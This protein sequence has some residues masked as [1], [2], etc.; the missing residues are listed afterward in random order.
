MAVKYSGI[1]H[2]GSINHVTGEGPN[3]NWVLP[4]AG[5][6]GIFPGGDPITIVPVVRLMEGDTLT[7]S[8][9]AGALPTGLA[10]DSSTG[11]ISGNVDNSEA[12]YS[13]TMRADCQGVYADRS[14]SLSV[15]TNNPPTWVTPAG[16]LGTQYES[17]AFTTTLVANGAASYV[18][19]SGTLPSGLN[20]NSNTG[21]ISGTLG[22]VPSTSTSFF[23]IRAK[24]GAQYADRAFN[25]T[26]K[27]NIPPQWIS[28][29]G[30]LGQYLE[31]T[32]V[33]YTFTASNSNL[34][35]TL[36]YS[37]IGN[38]AGLSLDANTGVLSGAL[39]LQS[40][41]FQDYNFTMVASNGLK[42]TPLTPPCKIRVY[43]NV[44]PV[45]NSSGTIATKL[46]GTEV[47][48][49]LSATDAFEAVS[50][51]LANG[52]TLPGDLVIESNGLLHGTLPIIETQTDYTF[53]ANA[54]D[55]SNLTSTRPLKITVL[56]NTKPAWETDSLLPNALEAYSYSTFVSAVDT[57]GVGRQITYT[58]NS[59]TLPFT[60]NANTGLISGL[61]PNVSGD[62]SYTFDIDATD[63]FTTNTRTFSLTINEDVP[64]VWNANGVYTYNV[65][66]KNWF[67]IVFSATDAN[68][69]PVTYY[70]SNGSLP[71]GLNFHNNEIKGQ[72]GQVASDTEYPLTIVASDG[73]NSVPH[74]FSI[75][76]KHNDAPIWN[77]VINGS[78]YEGTVQTYPLD[79]YD[80]NGQLVYFHNYGMPSGVTQSGNT[81]TV[82][83]PTVTQDTNISF[84]IYAADPSVSQSGQPTN[85]TP[86]TFTV[87]T[88]FNT[89]P[90]F[91]DSNVRTYNS[92]FP[93]SGTI[94]A[95]NS[96]NQAMQYTVT[97]GSLP[98]G[99]TLA[100]NGVLLGTTWEQVSNSQVYNFT[101]QADNGI[102]QTSRDY[103]FTILEHHDLTI[104][105]PSGEL[106]SHPTNT[107][108]SIQLTGT[109]PDN[110]PV[111]WSLA[112]GTTLP[113]YI[114]LSSSG[115][116]SGAFAISNATQTFNFEVRY[117]DTI[118]NAYASYSLTE[119]DAGVP[120]W[121]TP[122][123][124]LGS[125]YE[126][127]EVD[128]IA[129]ATDPQNLSL[130]FSLANGSSLPANCVVTSQGHVQGQFP[131]VT[132]NTTYTFDMVVTNQNDLSSTRTFS[133]TNL[134]DPY[135]TWQ[136][137]A[138][139]L[140]NAISGLYN[141]FDI[142]A[143]SLP[144][145][146]LTYELANGTSVPAG[147]GT[148]GN[149]S[150]F[151]VTGTPT[152]TYT[153]ST[154]NFTVSATDFYK[155]TTIYRD[156][157]INVIRNTD[158][159]WITNAGTLGTF[160]EGNTI[161]LSVSAV[162]MEG[163]AL[164]YSLYNSTSV[165]AGASFHPDGTITGTLSSVAQDTISNFTVLVSD[166]IRTS[167]RDFSLTTKFVSPPVWNTSAGSLGS[168]LEQ[169]TFSANVSAT[170]NGHLLQ[171]SLNSGS[172]PDSLSLNSNTGTISGYLDAISGNSNVTS[173]FT[174][175]VTD[176]ITMKTSTRSFSITKIKN[177]P[178][179]WD[180]AEGLIGSG[181]ESHSLSFTLVAHDPNGTDVEFS[182]Q[183]GNLPASIV[184]DTGITG[185]SLPTLSGTYP[186]VANNTDYQITVGAFDGA[187]RVD[188]T[189]T[190]TALFN[191][192]PVWVTNAGSLGNAFQNS[193][194][195]IALSSTDAEGNAITYTIAD[196]SLPSGLT[197]ASNGLI[198]GKLT[199]IGT[200]T[201]SSFTVTAND[202]SKTTDRIFSFLSKSPPPPI[203]VTAS[204]EI[205]NAV[206]TTTV[207]YQLVATSDNPVSYTVN[208]GTFP[209]ELTL[210]S[211][212][213]YI[214][215]KL[216]NVA[217][218]RTSTFII[219][220]SDTVY[221][222]STDRSF[223]IVDLVN[224]APVWVTGN[225]ISGTEGFPINVTLVATDS[226]GTTP[227]YTNIG[228]NFAPSMS[229]DTNTHTIT[230]TYPA[231]A[232]NSASYFLTVG[233]GDGNTVTTRT[234]TVTSVANQPPVWG[235][236]GS[237]GA[238]YDN[239]VVNITLTA[240]DPEA[241]SITYSLNSGTLPTGLSLVGN[242]L[243]GILSNTADT[244]SSFV[245]TANDGVKQTN[246]SFTLTKIPR[247]YW[248]TNAGTLTSGEELSSF[249]YQL[250][251]VD[252]AMS[253]SL[254]YV[255]ESKD[256]NSVNVLSNGL[257]TG[258]YPD[259]IYNS[260]ITV[261]AVDGNGYSSDSKV[262]NVLP[263]IA[264]PANAIS[265][266]LYQSARFNRVD[267]TA[268][269]ALRFLSAYSTDVSHPITTWGSGNAANAVIVTDPSG[270]H[271]DN[272][273][274]LNSQSFRYH[275]TNDN[276]SPP[277][278]T[279]TYTY[280]C[281]YYIPSGQSGN[282]GLAQFLSS[283]YVSNELFI[284]AY[285]GQDGTLTTTYRP[286]KTGGSIITM[287]TASGA[288]SFDTWIHYALVRNGN[289]VSVYLNGNL[290]TTTTLT[291]NFGVSG[292]TD[293]IFNSAISRI[294]VRGMS[295]WSIARY[296]SKFTPSWN[297]YTSPV[298]LSSPAIT[299]YEFSTYSQ[300]IVAYGFGNSTITYNAVGLGANA[301]LEANG[302]LHGTLPDSSVSINASVTASDG[303]G[304]SATSNIAYTISS[305]APIWS[306]ASNVLAGVNSTTV[307]TQFTAT[308]PVGHSLTYS[309]A[310]G[311]VPTGLTF[312]SNG[313]LNGQINVSQSTTYAFT[314]RA[315][316]ASSAKYTD[317]SFTYAITTPD[318]YGSNVVVLMNMDVAT[319]NAITNV[320]Q[321]LALSAAVTQFATSANTG[322]VSTSVTKF[323]TGSVKFDG[324][325]NALFVATPALS[326]FTIECW[327]YFNTITAQAIFSNRTF[328]D[329][330]A[331]RISLQIA[332]NGLLTLTAINSANNP[333]TRTGTTTLTTGT[334]YHIAV[335]KDISSQ[336][337]TLY[338][339]GVSQ[340][341]IA[342][343]IPSFTMSAGNMAI[344]ALYVSG[345]SNNFT[346][347][348]GYIDDFRITTS[349]RYTGAFTPPT[350]PVDTSF[351]A[352][353]FAS[354]TSTL[355]LTSGDT[356]SLNLRLVNKA[357][358][359][360]SIYTANG[361][362]P[363]GLSMSNT[364]VITG[365]VD[366]IGNTNTITSSVEVHLLDNYGRDTYK[367][368][369]FVQSDADPLW[370]N[371]TVAMDMS[372]TPGTLPT[373]ESNGK[374]VSQRVSSTTTAVISN[375]VSK[376]GGTSLVTSLSQTANHLA[377]GNVVAMPGDY[378]VEFWFYPTG[379]YSSVGSNMLCIQ[380][381]TGNPTGSSEYNFYYSTTYAPVVYA[382]VAVQSTGTANT[383]SVGSWHHIAVTRANGTTNF[384]VDGTSFFTTTTLSGSIGST[385]SNIF[386]GGNPFNG[387]ANGALGYFDDIR[388]TNGVARYTDTFTVPSQ[389]I[390]VVQSPVVWKSQG[391][392]YISNVSQTVK[393]LSASTF[394][395]SSLTYSVIS[396][397]TPNGITVSSN[398]Y[399]TGQAVTTVGTYNATVRAITANSWAYADKTF[400]FDVHSSADP[401]WANV[402]VLVTGNGPANTLPIESRFNSPVTQQLVSTVT[403]SI[404]SNVAAPYYSN[405]VLMAISGATNNGAG[406]FVGNATSLPGDLT[407]E[408]WVYPTA[409]AASGNAVVFSQYPSVSAATSNNPQYWA[410]SMG[411][412][413]GGVTSSTNSRISMY[414]TNGY[415]TATASGSLPWNQWNHLALTRANG[416]TNVWINGVKSSTDAGWTGTMG[417]V[418]T[419]WGFGSYETNDDN[420]FVGYMS[421]M[422]ITNGIARYTSDF[423]P[424]LTRFPSTD[425]APVIIGSNGSTI[426]VSA[427]AATVYEQVATSLNYD[428]LYATV[429][430]GALPRGL[431]FNTNGVLTGQSL[432]S[433][434]TSNTATLSVSTQVVA[435]ASPITYTFVTKSTS[436][437]Y[438]SNVVLFMNGDAPTDTIG[439]LP[440][441]QSTGKT[442]TRN[443]GTANTGLVSNTVTKSG[444]GNSIFNLSTGNQFLKVAGATGM[445]GDFTVETWVYFTSFQ[446]FNCV[447]SNYLLTS[448]N[449]NFFFC[450]TNTLSS[451][452]D[453]GGYKISL[454]N[455]SSGLGNFAGVT[456]L[457]ANTWYHFACTRRN[458]VMKLWLNGQLEATSSHS[459]WANASIGSQSTYWSICG[460]ENTPASWNVIG[461]VDDVRI[462]N[463]VARYDYGTGNTTFT[464]PPFPNSKG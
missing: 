53:S 174:L 297:D 140:G 213:G 217:T 312:N 408:A 97:S 263:T 412:A 168:Q 439:G 50:Y 194:V 454:R 186:V 62:T 215:G 165:P 104:T 75:T 464:L 107:F 147:M 3:V 271:T 145:N 42:S 157:S 172:L 1:I 218:D 463:T 445:T 344:G 372:G 55:I 287:S 166:G 21:V 321:E 330:A 224:Y 216:A 438:W 205:V 57:S 146:A 36:T 109:N 411:G 356:V 426:N 419:K 16:S 48:V 371:V 382:N 322:V 433:S 390:P 283:D 209:S 138:G 181:L 78:N 374:V 77:T 338:V 11:V 111:N 365:T 91:N 423:V 332:S 400:T 288:V 122:S 144:D 84:T 424:P 212:T 265:S 393:Q 299:G 329:S 234:F 183:G 380:P 5:D 308:S 246:A 72:L 397:A 63:G 417:T 52:S 415:R 56:A 339:N 239:T 226:N 282:V 319:S 73:K 123:G 23:T 230:G 19:Y 278:V 333:N 134:N 28:T 455:S 65:F 259:I 220:A 199:Y 281:W 8:I 69:K 169:T 89:P 351:I 219:K 461:Y 309:I 135:P 149:S 402:T 33:S 150:G 116:I 280:E 241:Q 175:D 352:P 51:S 162:D 399:V 170:S 428:P 459:S 46:G 346:P 409:A 396:G 233:A 43:K 59:G 130:T 151:R 17:T 143:T 349:V 398:G 305:S 92:L 128:F 392:Q 260:N 384:W 462:T 193:N 29:G 201:N 358:A 416:V 304:R 303:Y 10:M 355:Y 272:V 6:L 436:D 310:N 434:E 119:S 370:A 49:Q 184:F 45:W 71:S 161:S 40:G 105:T 131:F 85:E 442:V 229:F 327:V 39:P 273:L 456:S 118:S 251:A 334:W 141:A 136:T 449:N 231:V 261:H 318:V 225:T 435:N 139:S 386:I 24:N 337:M 284:N 256:S 347:M 448:A 348:N 325:Q 99:V 41:G 378:T 238:F 237:L 248:I 108:F 395:N 54:T 197:L 269:V 132:S 311:S 178:P 200:D 93:V 79:A 245:I 25:I 112:N 98:N 298:F 443:Y 391:T 211:T 376:F 192:P 429:T 61:A 204:G 148:S 350:L 387:A 117:T 345:T 340:G 292:M 7:F 450:A 296:T 437:P 294:Y 276:L 314:A 252:A 173:S 133:I 120:V 301:V 328:S 290:V 35:E 235:N 163:Q 267:A 242:A 2:S 279:S 102:K 335:T 451:S 266:A 317:K 208:S 38:P 336:T 401:L 76:V 189:F 444:Y 66:A 152:P 293:L 315:T 403:G 196:G 15:V 258:T 431:T 160:N 37:V 264:A 74:D 302:L 324:T 60:L 179:V 125:N 86:R 363:S 422:R 177:L 187:T 115:L 369:T 126:R 44:A 300:S 154:V 195:A 203:W 180:T 441:E 254:S 83:N 68:G 320:P 420:Q 81:V 275:D 359:T 190:V 457:S 191:H 214:T 101:V 20:L 30:T 274:Y 354:N 164:V 103:K 357:F 47:T 385:T 34:D 250:N 306:N 240:T 313:L 223:T 268:E 221:G 182:N 9:V 82:T 373:E 100:S 381:G 227:V 176:Q 343:G 185:V 64:P 418:S 110:L 4:E 159:V 366:S 236:T 289:N 342:S 427:N 404:S 405:S 228:S 286:I 67:D 207:N 360:V 364:G 341:T 277:L 389:P 410:L 171:Y 460:Y 70:I 377:I 307:S 291:Q 90:A 425:S 270:S 244:V 453:L 379:V 446:Q 106:G 153:N 206:A 22:A 452:N 407:I 243:T 232:G 295:I 158:P 167:T 247:P 18:L 413:G 406:I 375:T 421:E 362:L 32:S 447:I 285:V 316:D 430:S 253:G 210:N 156:F 13:F 249:S 12:S 129:Y 121:T 142:Y 58:V 394:S 361:T 87:T 388:I 458:N 124:S 323:G 114:T 326:T 202:S 188:R 127:R 14:F 257:V 96:G 113:N 198:H 367:T 255:V 94:H 440:V 331:N 80:P 88:L 353:Y 414:Y 383:I 262:F 137:N 95:I 155:N 26:N 222:L 27:R 31:N 368:L 432:E